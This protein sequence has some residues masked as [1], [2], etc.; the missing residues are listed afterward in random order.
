MAS[1]PRMEAQAGLG[2]LAS[3]MVSGKICY[4]TRLSWGLPKLEL[5]EYLLDF[6]PQ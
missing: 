1:D 6:G 5:P 2:S 4:L 3:F